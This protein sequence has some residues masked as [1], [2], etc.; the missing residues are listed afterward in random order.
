MFEH[1]IQ[2]PYEALRQR[3]RGDLKWAIY[4]RMRWRSKNGAREAYAGRQS[5]SRDVGCSETAVRE[6]LATLAKMGLLVQT[7]FSRGGRGIANGYRVI[8]VGAKAAVSMVVAQTQ[9]LV[10]SLTTKRP[11]RENIIEKV[12][13]EGEPETPLNPGSPKFWVRSIKNS[14]KSSKS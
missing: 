13:I 4:D 5:L 12:A 8:L 3:R 2:V 11:S 10:S 1:Y 9:K 14:L 6:T 7:F